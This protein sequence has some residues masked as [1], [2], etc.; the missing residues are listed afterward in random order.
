[1]NALTPGVTTVVSVIVCSVDVDSSF[2]SVSSSLN[3]CPNSNVSVSSSETPKYSPPTFVSVV[4]LKSNVV[5]CLNSDVTVR[6]REN[7][8][9]IWCS[10]SV[11]P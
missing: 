4:C 7:V 6:V 3:D 5:V 11:E 8:L 10:T 9:E 1:M 2:V